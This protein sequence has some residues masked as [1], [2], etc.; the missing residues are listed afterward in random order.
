MSDIQSYKI[1][2]KIS[3]DTL[4][5]ARFAL[6]DRI[7]RS[8]VTLERPDVDPYMVDHWK[9]ELKKA[10]AALTELEAL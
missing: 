7:S 10:R 5:A 1:S 6:Y 3:L 2:I 4:G 9:Y 8:T